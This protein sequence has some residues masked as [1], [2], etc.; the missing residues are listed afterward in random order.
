MLQNLLHKKIIAKKIYYINREKLWKFTLKKGRGGGLVAS[1]QLK[2]KFTETDQLSGN[3]PFLSPQ[4]IIKTGKFHVFNKMQILKMS[5]IQE[6]EP[7][8]KG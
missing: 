7:P 2:T 6:Y 3:P 8:I 5:Q 1:N 4:L